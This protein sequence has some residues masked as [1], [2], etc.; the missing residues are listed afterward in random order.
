MKICLECQKH[1][2]AN[3]WRCPRCGHSPARVEDFITLAPQIATQNDGFNPALFEQYA[4]IEASHF[5]F[6]GRNKIIGDAI[7]AS[8]AN[9]RNMLEIGCGNGGVLSEVGRNFPG[10]RLS[11]G[12]AFL[13]GL[14]YAAKRIPDADLY[15]M[16]ATNIPFR[17]EFDII[18]AF[19]VLE[20]IDDDE[21]A[22]RQ[23]FSACKPGGGIVVT[24][25]QHPFLWSRTDEYAHHKR[26]YTRKELL[27]KV[28][29]AGFEVE[30][31]TSFVSLLLP[32]MM[33]SRFM[34]RRHEQTENPIDKGF[35]I[36]KP[37]NKLLGWVLGLE[38]MAI[39]IG[40][41]FS[42]GGSLLLVA[43]KD[44]FPYKGTRAANAA[45]SIA[46]RE[47]NSLLS[48]SNLSS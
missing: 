18:G 41:S 45:G 14:A 27:R 5:W 37:I 4:E 3:N 34:Q 40:L 42:A 15:Q 24:V 38:R 20:H 32:L 7:M 19:D 33:L 48:N 31:V 8:F 47:T 21:R 36:S 16:D 46:R 39:R 23:M 10:L 25:P 1:F 13:H 43:R 26:R 2:V 30:R 17:E 9:A 35:R 22:L 12:D 28:E 44:L 11:G 29:G 6:V